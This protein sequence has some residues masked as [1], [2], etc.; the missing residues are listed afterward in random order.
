[1]QAEDDPD[2]AWV[3]ALAGSDPLRA[4]RAVEEAG[5]GRRLFS[6]LDRAH[7]SG[8]RPSYVEIDA[9]LELFAIVRLTRPTHVVEVGVSS[10]VSSAYLLA[11]LAKNGRGTLHSIDRPKR[12]RTGARRPGERLTASWALPP[13]HTPGWAI[14]DAYRPRWD[15]R[16]G[17]KKDVIPLLV[18][19]LPQIDLFVYDVPHDDDRAKVEFRLLDRR[20][21]P[22]GVVIVDHGPG[23]GLCPSLAWWGARRGSSTTGRTGLG[24]HGFR[25]EV[26]PTP[27]RSRRE[28]PAS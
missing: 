12:E 26:G 3:S 27:R 19:E 17:D 2:T 5:R 22:H 25:S 7:R 23:G 9:P 15:L 13:G 8:G 6:S 14:P 4:Q 10:G 20:L 1:M 21:S 18:E 28:A 24:L 16:V 11:G